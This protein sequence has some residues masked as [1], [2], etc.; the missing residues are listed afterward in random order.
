MHDSVLQFQRAE[1]EDPPGKGKTERPIGFD[2]DAALEAAM[3]I[4]WA[5]GCEG[6]SMADLIQTRARVRS[7]DSN[8]G[9][10]TPAGIVSTRSVVWSIRIAAR[11]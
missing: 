2:G 8:T 3:L 10:A 1:Q 9:S 6:S 11:T 7:M 5:R 4:F